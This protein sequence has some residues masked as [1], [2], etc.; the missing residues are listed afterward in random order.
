MVASRTFVPTVVVALLSFAGLAA[1]DKTDARSADLIKAAK[2]F[3]EL[4]DKGEFAKATDGFDETMRKVL[5]PD[6]L[7]KTWQKVLDEAGDFRKQVGS[8]LEKSGKYEIVYVTCEFARMKRDARVVFDKDRKITGLFFG[9]VRK[10]TPTGPEEIWEGTLKVGPVELRLVFHL[11]KQKDGSFAGTMDSPNEGIKGIVLDEVEVKGDKVRLEVKS[12]KFVFEGQRDK[13]GKEIAGEFK[14]SGLSLPLVLKRV[15]KATEGKRPQTPQK[16]YPYDEIQVAYE[17]KKGGIHLA[18]A[19]TL[20]RG[21]GPFPAV[22]L[23]TGSGAQDR[24]ETILGHK[25]FL[26]L[27]DYLTRRGIA[28]LRLDDRGVGGST[29]N[30][31][32][33]TSADF[34]DDVLAGVEFLKGRKEINP[35]R[36]GL[37][38][39][40][41]G[42]I[43][44]PLVASRS[45]D[46][47]F[48]VL[49]AGTGMPGDE[50]LYRQAAAILKV[51][52]ADA[53]QLARQKALQE[54]L[55]A[56]L[57]QEKDNAAA[58][59]KLRAALDEYR[60]GLGKEDK[61]QLVDALPMLEGQ[62]QVV[63][64][65]WFRHFLDY[66]PRPALRE[67]SCPVLALNGEKDLQVDPK[68]NLPSIAA[69]LKEGGN[70]D[71]TTKELPNLNHLFQTCKTG[72]VSE[73]GAIEET[74]APVALEAVAEW[75]LQRAAGPGKP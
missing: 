7:K 57:R 41:E 22:L 72:A 16:P 31:Q 60:A 2:T 54:R 30:V 8:R 10:P 23:I 59:K 63:L 6:Q 65:P 20:P 47:A 58:G 27:A 25:P 44:A 67:V 14:Q 5:P 4:L 15:A 28:V 61:K 46:V 40:S 36:I 52:G 18:G 50:V 53:E 71:F 29:G 17:N 1:E 74:I 11:F 26:V 45:R 37:I 9:P 49:L 13:D 48:I 21:Q 56:V 24:D 51:T 38:G 32:D 3:V 43:I 34:A 39:H 62:V 55:F 70:K 35:A 66:D 33:A 19:L 68:V 42:G 64:T 69:A 75:I 12:S 73:Y